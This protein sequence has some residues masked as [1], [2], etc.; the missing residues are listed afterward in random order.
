LSTVSVDEVFTQN[1]EKMSSA[2]G[3]FA[4]KLHWGCASGPRWGTS[5]LQTL[6]LPTPG[7]NP[8]GA[9]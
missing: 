5:V 6:S 3:G 9:H 1:F 4:P 7:K 8:A 2:F